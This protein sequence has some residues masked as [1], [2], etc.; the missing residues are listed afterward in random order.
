MAFVLGPSLF[1]VPFKVPNIVCDFAIGPLLNRP[2]DPK[3]PKLVP[4]C[5]YIKMIMFNPLWA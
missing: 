5:G 4:C 1:G 2:N 3:S